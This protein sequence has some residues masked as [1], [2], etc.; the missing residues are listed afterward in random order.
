MTLPSRRCTMDVWAANISSTGRCLF[1][2]LL[3]TWY[4]KGRKIS[5]PDQC[6]LLSAPHTPLFP[7]P[8]DVVTTAAATSTPVTLS[9]PPLLL[10]EMANFS[11]CSAGCR[12]RSLSPSEEGCCFFWGSGQ[13]VRAVPELTC[14]CWNWASLN[15]PVM[16]DTGV[17]RSK[18][19]RIYWQGWLCFCKGCA[20]AAQKEHDEWNRP[21]IK[22]SW[23]FSVT[24]S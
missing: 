22:E 14:S 17:C 3:A 15:Y 23:H 11:K 24:S 13:L 21:S 2:H 12:G 1:L 19:R 4:H 16:A 10:A 8:R 20:Q 7:G 18:T 6:L 5:L 9:W